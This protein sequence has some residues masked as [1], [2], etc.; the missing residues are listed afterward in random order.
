MGS[1]RI[2]TL[3]LSLPL[4]FVL[5]FDLTAESP[6]GSPEHW[7]LQPRSQ[8][9]LPHLADPALRARV[10]TPVDAFILARLQEAGLQPAPEADRRTLIRRLTFDLTG[11]PPTPDQIRDFL[12]DQ[13]P[14]AYEKLVDRLLGS[15]AYGERW[16]Q[17]WL[18][19]VRFAETEGFEYDRHRAGAWRYRDYV[20]RACNEDRPYDRFLTEQLAGDEMGS[21]AELQVA[22]GFH[23][24][25][26]VRR[27][28]GN[29]EVAFSRNEVLT[30]RTDAIGAVFLGLTV[31]CARCHDHK[32]DP[33]L[34]SDYYRLQAYLASTYEH[35]I[36]LADADTQRAWKA[37]N[38]KVRSKIKQLK[39]AVEKA[40]GEARQRLQEQLRQAEHSLPPPLPT[41]STVHNDDARRTAIHVLKRGQVDRKGKQVGPRPLDVLL[42]AG[43]PELPA[44]LKKPRTALARWLTDPNHPLTARVMVNR[45]WGYHFGQGIVATPNDLGVNG[46]RPTHPELL[47]WLANTFVSGGWRLKPLHRLLVL[48]STYR[49]SSR[50]AS[51]QVRLADPDNRLLGRFSRR[52]LE[53]EE[54]R[55]SMLAISGIFNRKAGGPSVIPPVEQD[56]ID[57]LY[58]PAQWAITPDR[59]EH[60]RRSI[61]LIAKRNLRLPFAEAFDQPNLQTSCPRR[62]S[63][64]HALQALELLNG[65]TSN[66]LAGAFA[67]RL[68]REVGP[69]PSRQIERAYQLATARSPTRRELQLARAFLKKQPLREFTLALFNLNAFLYVD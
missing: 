24:L 43:T 18:D 7:S 17:H 39:E 42:P 23:R 21:R 14:D 41:L 69:D 3:L 54:I 38:D 64:T 59:R 19:V 55:D 61:Y 6:E 30:E 32:F 68:L 48:S 5:A 10:R 1:H 35:D 44:D 63:S 52:R 33:I 40:T 22:A 45:I 46:A 49:Q 31:G 50:P 37:R 26:P 4:F 53:A 20:V 62:V 47:D 51:T 58:D 29:P 12:A 36:V 27:N 13:A 2:P 66:R 15:P 56:L 25:G 57:L 8:P 11:L 67:A 28:A 34:Q 65:Q 9:A 16:A 60:N